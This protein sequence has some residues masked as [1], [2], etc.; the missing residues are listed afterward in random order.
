MRTQRCVTSAIGTSKNIV[1]RDLLTKPDA[2][3]AENA[4]LIIEHHSRSEKRPFR[5]YDFL[6]DKTAVAAAIIEGEFLKIA[7]AGFVAD[8]TVERMIDQEKLHDAVL[9]VFYE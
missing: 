8:R 9:A 1:I 7:L 4:A 2:A 3:R 6:F 5:F